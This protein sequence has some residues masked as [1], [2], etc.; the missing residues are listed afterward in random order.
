M[1]GT[2]HGMTGAVIA[3]LIKEPLVAVPLSVMSHFACD[4]IPH[5]GVKDI[6]NE[7]E[8][9]GRKFTIILIIDFLVAITIMALLGHLFPSQRV[10]IW[11]CMIAAAIP[12]VMWAYYRLYVEIIKKR[13]P[14]LG[15]IARFHTWI[16]WSQ[17]SKG[18]Y[19]EL[20]WFIGTG[21]IILSRR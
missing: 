18:A 9:F 15:P 14:I 17:T 1:T 6:P 16:Q 19:L 5:F 3:L 4:A 21:L 7:S 11:A 2:N 13:T 10:L 20:A 8:V 12:D